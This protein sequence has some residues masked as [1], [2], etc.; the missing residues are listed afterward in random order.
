MQVRAFGEVT[1]YEARGQY[2]MIVKKLEQEG[3]GTLQ[4]RFEALKRQLHAEGLFSADQK[5][6]IPNFPRTIAIVT[7][8]TG[9]AVRDVLN[10]VTRRA[11]WV[12]SIIIPVPVQ[13]AEAHL[14][15]AHAIGLLSSNERTGLPK[16]DTIVLCRGGGSIED[17]W[18][19]N[20]E[21]LARAIYDCPIP[22]ISAVGHE[23]DFTIA[24]FVADLRAPTPSAAAELAVPDRNTLKRQLQEGRADFAARVIRRLGDL[25]RQ[26]EWLSKGALMREPERQIRESRMRLDN[27]TESLD[28]MA[29]DKILEEKTRIVASRH[30]LLQARP[31]RVLDRRA[32]RLAALSDR[33]DAATSHRFKEQDR[34]VA[35]AAHLLK[36]LGPESVF[37]RGFSLTTTEDGKPLTSPDATPPGTVIRTHLAEGTLVSTVN[38]EADQEKS[39]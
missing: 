6:P 22:V 35:A 14:Q 10:I 21:S 15:I 33:L 32:M 24:D 9:A 34:R 7:S 28:Q 17:L 18:N 31:D 3:H 5:R 16:I 29:K 11:P 4:A 39:K 2:Q 30:A 12:R 25:S 37:K 26:L 8:P 20:E 1:V 19:F 23:I 27:L 36:S 13:G 38:K